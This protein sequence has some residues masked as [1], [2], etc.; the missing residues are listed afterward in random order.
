MQ[1]EFVTAV[2]IGL[3]PKERK[4]NA[5]TLLFQSIS[6]ILLRLHNLY[7]YIEFLNA[8]NYVFPTNHLV[9]WCCRDEC[10][11]GGDSREENIDRS[12]HPKSRLRITFFF[13]LFYNFFFSLDQK[14]R[15]TGS[16]EHD[17][18]VFLLSQERKEKKRNLK[19][20]PLAA[21]G[22]G[23]ATVWRVLGNGERHLNATKQAEKNR[24]LYIYIYIHKDVCWSGGG[25]YWHLEGGGA[26]VQSWVNV[27]WS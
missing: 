20:A 14:D 4:K 12:F 10:G 9:V 22:C 21:P 16:P 26:W 2:V 8:S 5:T 27:A 15:T 18:Q 3:V 1:E 25:V 23:F 24:I 13:F 11:G 6:Y 19:G 7:K 17:M